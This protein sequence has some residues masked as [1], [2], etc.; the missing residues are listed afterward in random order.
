VTGHAIMSKAVSQ[1]DSLQSDNSY[2]IRIPCRLGCE[3]TPKNVEFSFHCGR[4]NKTV[5]TLSLGAVAQRNRALLALR[6]L[7]RCDVH[8][9]SGSLLP[10]LV[11]RSKPKS[12]LSAHPHRVKP[13]GQTT[14]T[15]QTIA[16]IIGSMTYSHILS[17]TL[18]VTQPV[19]VTHRLSRE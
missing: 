3:Q 6:L 10:C 12:N 1:C 9:T 15:G 7:I 18:T 8:V 2:G 19:S 11:L 4:W 5:T 13:T 16:R 17:W 14:V